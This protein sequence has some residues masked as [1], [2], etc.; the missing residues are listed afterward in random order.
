MESAVELQVLRIAGHEA[1]MPHVNRTPMSRQRLTP[2][3]S[4]ALTDAD[5]PDPPISPKLY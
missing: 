5:V 2:S 1:D 3:P 4:H